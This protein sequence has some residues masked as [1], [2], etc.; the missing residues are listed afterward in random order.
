METAVPGTDLDRQVV[1]FRLADGS[2]AVDIA[3]VREIIRPQ[4]ITVVPL[5]PPFVVGVINL[6]GSIVPVL[7]LRRR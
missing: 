1:V 5:A 7:D 2:Y 3:T 4:L 6:R